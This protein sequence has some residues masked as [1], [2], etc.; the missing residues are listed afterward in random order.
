MWHLGPNFGPDNFDSDNFDSDNLDS[1]NLMQNLILGFEIGAITRTKIIIIWSVLCI[2]M[3]FGP[4]M[5]NLR[6]FGL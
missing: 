4:R 6:A 5:D 1:D 2:S 3:F